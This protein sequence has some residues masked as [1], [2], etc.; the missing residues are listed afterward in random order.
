V[1]VRSTKEGGWQITG[2]ELG[3]RLPH[4]IYRPGTPKKYVQE[5]ESKLRS[6][7]RASK[8]LGR[9]PEVSLEEAIVRYLQEF[10]GKG[11]RQVVN[12][13]H[14]LTPFVTG[15]RLSQVVDAA[16][17]VRDDPSVS[18]STRNRRL[19][20]LRRVG[21]LAYRRWG[22]LQA[23]LHEKIETLPENPARSVYLSRGEVA[24][25]LKGI[26]NRECRRAALIAVFTGMRRSE[27]CG[28]KP[29]DI[30]G[31]SIC[32]R[33]S[34][35]GKPRNIP[36]V[37]GLEFA[38]RRL[39]IGVHRDTLSHAVEKASG[40]KVR[41]HDLRHTT[42]SLLI[43]AGVPL[44]TVGAVLGHKS[45]QTTKRYAHLD[46][47]SMENA[48]ALLKPVRRLHVTAKQDVSKDGTNS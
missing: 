38:F 14:Q 9:V 36:I 6:D 37:P 19:A 43:N 13:A 45:L 5:V 18:F 3:V 29:D 2:S 10:Q 24:G 31:N 27:I 46:Q 40:G 30:S 35:N 22:W 34:K 8:E 48:V 16:S 26:R 44:F 39:P 7:I 42:A 33:D 47:K 20:I 32:L 11:K 12:H 4:K 1:P 28:L 23:P 17:A 25:L 41:F 15:R 21:S